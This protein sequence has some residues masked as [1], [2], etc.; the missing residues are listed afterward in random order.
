MRFGRSVAIVAATLSAAALT[1]CGTNVVPGLTNNFIDGNWNLIGSGPFAQ[2]PAISGVFQVIANQVS[3]NFAIAIQ[4]SGSS[5]IGGAGTPLTGPV[6]SDGS[7]TLSQAP[8]SGSGGTI[9]TTVT[10][11]LRTT[12]EG[13]WSGTYSIVSTE[14]GC[15]INQTGKFTAVR[16]TPLTGNYVGSPGNT[17]LGSGV[18]ITASLTQASTLND[19]AG[20]Q[21]Q[22]VEIPY[23]PVSGT[24]TVTGSPCFTQG[25]AVAPN[26]GGPFPGIVGSFFSLDFDMD[27]GSKL[28]IGGEI[29]NTS[30][31][32]LTGLPGEGA[33]FIVLGG[34]CNNASGAIPLTRQ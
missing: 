18:T 16:F 12:A 24:I 19:Y 14:P 32:Q 5:S 20:P 30:A 2:L 3:G 33:N 10:G 6:A 11:T 29:A 22:S 1:S 34:N 9:Q 15:S 7:F 26:P 25:T 23:I 8:A 21:N 13:S 17:K 27:D 4:C 28:T 31:T